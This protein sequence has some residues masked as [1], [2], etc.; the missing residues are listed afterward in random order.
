VEKRW[1]RWRASGSGAAQPHAGSKPR[2]LKDHAEA[3]QSAVEHHPDATLEAWREQ[4]A[5]QGPRGR[6]ATMWRA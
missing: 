1:H 6:P 4:R 3:L 5:A 2:A